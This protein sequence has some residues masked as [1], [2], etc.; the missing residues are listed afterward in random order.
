MTGQTEP[1]A[2]GYVRHYFMMPAAELARARD[3]VTRAAAAENLTLQAIHV[4]ELETE[5]RAFNAVV[6]AVEHGGV[7][8]VIVPT[9]EH[10]KPRP[11]ERSR[12]IRLEL[13]AGVRV[14]VA[15]SP[16]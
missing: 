13:E 7:S 10:L 5:P 1:V 11:G 9:L 12:R 4:E 2:I 16:P 14:L 15:A 6:K 8:V 3:H